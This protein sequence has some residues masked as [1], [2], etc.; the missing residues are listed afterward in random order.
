MRSQSAVFTLHKDLRVPL[1]DLCPNAVRQI[2][3]PRVVHD[4]A[5]KFL[6]LSGISEFTVFLDLDGLARYIDATELKSD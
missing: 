5:Q 2:V 1:E 4:E 3:V 6:R